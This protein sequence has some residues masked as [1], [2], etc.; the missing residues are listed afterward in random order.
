MLFHL[1]RGALLAA[2]LLGGATSLPGQAVQPPGASVLWSAGPRQGHEV[3]AARRAGRIS[4]ENGFLG[5][6]L[7]GGLTA[8]FLGHQLCTASRLG[9]CWGTAAWWAAIGGAIGGL[10]G[11]RAGE[12][13]QPGE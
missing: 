8:G 3:D 2:L 5:G 7:I 12:P 13:E 9:G 1:S 10:I 6:A 4:R 11:A